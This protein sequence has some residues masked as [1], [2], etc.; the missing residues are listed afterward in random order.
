MQQNLQSCITLPALR[1]PTHACQTAQGTENVCQITM[2]TDHMRVD[3]FPVL[4]T[5]QHRMADAPTDGN[6]AGSR[7]ATAHSQPTHAPHL[8]NTDAAVQMPMVQRGFTSGSPF[9]KGHL[10]NAV[11]ACSS[12]LLIS[13]LSQCVCHLYS[14]KIHQT[15]Y[16]LLALL[17]CR[18]TGRC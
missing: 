16:L 8:T 2:Q 9:Q 15:L 4:A 1:V 13:V 17:L 18:G 3:V 11:L 12:R 5:R 14:W 6:V 7:K 10:S